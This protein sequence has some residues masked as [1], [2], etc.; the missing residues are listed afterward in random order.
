MHDH[1][2]RPKLRRKVNPIFD[3]L[4]TG[5]AR[6]FVGRLP[7]LFLTFRT[8]HIGQP[9]AIV[10]E[11]IAN[12]GNLRRVIDKIGIPLMAPVNVGETGVGNSAQKGRWVALVCFEISCDRK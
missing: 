10:T 2:I 6:I 9:Q 11:P 7:E 1:S 5:Q 12:L 4:D 8:M 3:Q